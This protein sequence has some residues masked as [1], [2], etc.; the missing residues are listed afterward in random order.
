MTLVGIGVFALSYTPVRGAL[1]NVVYSVAPKIW[2][3]GGTAHDVLTSFAVNFRSKDALVIENNTLRSDIDR[4]QAQV[5]DRNLLAEKVIKLEEA[6]GRTQSDDRVLAYVLAGPGLSSYDTLVLDAGEE[7]GITTGDMVVY[8]GV[9]AIGEIVETSTASS[10]VKLFSTPGE[11]HFVSIGAQSVPAK[12]TGKGMGNF[13]AKV[14]QDSMVSLGDNVI[15]LKGGLILGTVSLVEEKP[16][17]PFKRVLFRT[18][19]NITWIRSV[20]IIIGKRS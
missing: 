11:E 5:L 16:A 7:N 18:P 14:P 19:F 9:G 17:E 1:T 3:I 2:G 13:E 6:L 12:A 4:M 8:A 20:E 15:S 10:K